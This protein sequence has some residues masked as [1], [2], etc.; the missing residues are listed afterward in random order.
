LQEAYIKA[1]NTFAFDSF[2]R[3]VTLSGD[4]ATLAVGARSEDSAANT[5]G[6]DE[7]DNSKSSSGAV[8]VFARDERQDEWSQVAYVKPS[9]TDEQ[10]SFGIS[11]SLSDDGKLLAVGADGE[12]SAAVGVEGDTSDNSAMK[13]GA[14]YVFG[15]DRQAWSQAAY[16]KA[17]NPEADD[18]F[19]LSVALSG[20]GQTLGI[21]SNED[22]AD[23]G[24]GGDQSNNSAAGA[25]AVYVY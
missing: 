25:G 24:I 4:G 13:A 5:I 1:S 16:I 21:G 3:A 6:G 8:Y 14:V 10:D 20:D 11:V 17:P 2:G 15:R 23:I 7:N 12:S 9:N 19:G 18:R 22:G